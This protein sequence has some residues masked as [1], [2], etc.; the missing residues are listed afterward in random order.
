MLALAQ[1]VAAQN[2]PAAANLLSKQSSII[3][4]HPPARQPHLIAATLNRHADMVKLL[5]NYGA[6]VDMPS[7][8]SSPEEPQCTAEVRRSCARSSERKHP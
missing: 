2:V 8:P 5:L 1:Y 7:I 3:D 4:L 6:H